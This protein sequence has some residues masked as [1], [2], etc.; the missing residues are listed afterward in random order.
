MSVPVQ[1]DFLLELTVR[2]MTWSKSL[3]LETVIFW[4]KRLFNVGA[5]IHIYE[6]FGTITQEW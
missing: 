3:I 5:N 4:G 1:A 6:Y 2:A